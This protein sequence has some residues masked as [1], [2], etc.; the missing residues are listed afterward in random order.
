MAN[1]PPVTAARLVE[2]IRHHLSRL[3]QRLLPAPAAMME[4]IVV[5]WQA[6]AI[7]VAAERN[8]KVLLLQRTG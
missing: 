8:F 1:V 6:Q 2:R 7:T 5:T 4:M 3:N